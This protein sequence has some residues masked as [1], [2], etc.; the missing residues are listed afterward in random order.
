MQNILVKSLASSLYVI[1][2]IFINRL[3]I[4][5]WQVKTFG[6]VRYNLIVWGVCQQNNYSK[7]IS[8]R[9]N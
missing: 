5:L 3:T 6:K 4:L 2:L 9:G 1:K 7:G 8:F